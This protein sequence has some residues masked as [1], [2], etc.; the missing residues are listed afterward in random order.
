LRILLVEDDPTLQRG[1]AQ[2]LVTAGHQPVVAG[3]GLYAD[4]LLATESFDLLVL[5]L[6]LPKLDG[7]SVLERLRRRQ[8]TLPVLVLSARDQTTDRIRGLDSGAD[9]YMTKPFELSEFEARVRALLRRGQGAVPNIGRLHWLRDR[10]EAVVDDK[11]LELSRHELTVL[12][13]LVQ[14]PGRTVAKSSLALLL[15]EDGQAADD[16]LVE[17]YVHR[18]RRKLA[19]A[20]VEI[21]TIRGLGYRLYE[22]D[23]VRR[24]Q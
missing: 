22:S 20:E 2:A 14:N 7:L 19:D 17:V 8:Q 13:A 10:R 16:N 3:D 15:G 5:D 6:G 24:K 4:T 1:L 12:E 23:H 21:R 18:L 9:D 11:A